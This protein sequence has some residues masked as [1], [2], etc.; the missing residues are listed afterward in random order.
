MLRI[1]SSRSTELAPLSAR[2]RPSVFLSYRSSSRVVTEGIGDE[3]E[4]LGDNRLLDRFFDVEAISK[5]MDFSPTIHKGLLD[6]DGIVLLL[7]PEFFNSPWCVHELHFAL[8]QHETRGISL[9]WA[10]CEEA[11]AAPQESVGDVEPGLECERAVM[12]WLAAA[13]SKLP[14][15]KLGY[16]QS[17]LGDRINRVFDYGL[18]LSDQPVR[19]CSGLNAKSEAYKQEKETFAYL[20]QRILTR[21]KRMYERASLP[22]PEGLDRLTPE[23]GK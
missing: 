17:H 18:R 23:L 2:R 21:A 16:A 1:Q 3:L 11:S 14:A 9:F 10:W 13:Y 22:F 5:D 20:G 4:K 7:S 19:Y 8:G 6:S 15:A 12:R